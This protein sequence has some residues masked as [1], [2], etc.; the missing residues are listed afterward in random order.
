MSNFTSV[1]IDLSYIFVKRTNQKF[2]V[3]IYD[4]TLFVTFS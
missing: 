4:V 3:I 1:L 2:V